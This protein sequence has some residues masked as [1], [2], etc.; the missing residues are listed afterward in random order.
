MNDMELL[1]KLAQETPLPAP[2]ELDVARARLAAAIT[3]SPA[4]G[5]AGGPAG[6]QRRAR[7]R[8]VLTGAVAAGLAAAVAAV[9]VSVLVSVPGRPGGIASTARPTDTTGTAGH[10]GTAGPTSSA[11]PGVDAGAAQVLRHAALAALQLP[12]GAPRPDQFVYTKIENGDGSLYQSWLS[13]DGTGTGL[14]RGAGGGPA[15]IYLPGCRDGRQI[16]VNAPK[17]EGGTPG[18]QP[19]VPQPAYLPAMPAS[20]AA[21]RSYLE[22]NFGVNPASPGYLNNFGKTIDDLLSQVYLSSGQRAALYALMAQ[23]PGF[24]LIPDTADCIGRH[25]VG[26]GWSLPGGGGKTVII[27]SPKTYAE[28]GINT[29]GEAGQ[30]GG[31]ALLQLAIVDNAGQ[32]P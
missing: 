25:G 28:L 15:N 26:V 16:G 31:S 3:A 30:K 6:H 13:V 4:S 7:G 5:V 10:T 22:Q 12:A 32:L 19:C 11:G 29:V 17:T 27:F 21:L 24:T 2:A 9:L 14:I 18:G 20:P 23:T 1:R 8:L